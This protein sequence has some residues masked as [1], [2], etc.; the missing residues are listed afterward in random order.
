VLRILI[1]GCLGLLI[2]L[3]AA[4][5]E[6]FFDDSIPNAVRDGRVEAEL[7][8]EHTALVPGET[9]QLG[10]RLKMDDGWHTYWKNPGDSGMATSLHWE[11]P[12]DFN[13]HDIDWPAPDYFEVG[14]LASYG[15]EGQIVLPVRLDVPEDFSGDEVTLR[16]T[17]DWLV[18]KELC[19]PGSATLVIT[20]PVVRNLANVAVDSAN[21]K[22]FTRAEA[23]LPLSAD[24]ECVSATKRGETY[25]LT[26]RE[27][28]SFRSDDLSAMT[29]RFYPA[30]PMA[31]AMG[32]PQGFEFTQD[33]GVHVTLSANALSDPPER[34]RGVLVLRRGEQ[35]QPIE[36]DV[37]LRN[38]VDG[39]TH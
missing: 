32:E 16:A 27:V 24:D 22:L 7:I 2:V 33:G 38:V 35:L 6:S 15:Y 39:E 5:Q 19:E 25:T 3:T 8:A 12:D 21:K 29:A 23:R 36:I 28:F 31:I 9:A 18:C 20:L 14:G 1:A 4:G 34:L 17:A 30:D 10:L 11:T 37:P 26:V 13:I